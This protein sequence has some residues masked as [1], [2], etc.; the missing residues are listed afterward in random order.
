MPEASGAA[1]PRPVPSE[2]P[3]PLCVA[4]QLA[5]HEHVEGEVG[6]RDL[7]PAPCA[8]CGCRVGV[9]YP[10]GWVCAECEWRHGEQP[11][12]FVARPTL[13]VVYYLGF[14][15]EI[16]IGT[17]G[18]P[19]RRIAALPH[20]EV[21]AFEPGGRTL[22]QR[23]HAQFGELRLRGGEWFARG[24]PLLAH[25]ADLRLGVDDPWVEYGRWVSRRRA[26]DAS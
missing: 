4:H 11:D 9:R 8:A 15:D 19:R 22:E 26:R 6:A 16:K 23:R 2:S 12:A 21:L 5:V 10:S 13:E 14:R 7:L 18:N 3:F 25:I 24:E 20:D 17:S 1:C